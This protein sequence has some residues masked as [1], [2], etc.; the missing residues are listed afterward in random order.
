MRVDVH[1]LVV[2]QLPEETK[3]VLR[4]GQVP[5]A[6]LR[7]IGS[8]AIGHMGD[9][10]ARDAPVHVML[11]HETAGAGEMVNVPEMRHHP[12]LPQMEIAW[13]PFGKTLMAANLTGFFT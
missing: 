10:V 3:P 12:H 4:S 2:V 9:L 1:A 13:R 7:R 5:V 8:L 11:D 6:G